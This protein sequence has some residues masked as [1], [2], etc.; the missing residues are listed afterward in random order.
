MNYR[1]KFASLDD[2]D[3]SGSIREAYGLP[4]PTE[5]SCGLIDCVFPEGD[6]AERMLL[7]SGG[8]RSALLALADQ[9]LAAFDTFVEIAEGDGN[10]SSEKLAAIRDAA[11]SN[12]LLKDELRAFDTV[13]PIWERFSARFAGLR[14]LAHAE[15]P[16]ADPPHGDGP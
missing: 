2:G 11:S 10:A 16:V 5:G 13:R 1:E 8:S 12:P 4:A 7:A 15:Q 3:V 14:S 9:V 6:P